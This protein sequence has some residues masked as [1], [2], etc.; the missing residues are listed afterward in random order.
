MTMRLALSL[1]LIMTSMPILMAHGNEIQQTPTTLAGYESFYQST[2]GYDDPLC[3][4]WTNG[5]ETCKRIYINKEAKISCEEKT[6]ACSVG[7]VY[8]EIEDEKLASK[9]CA[10]LSDDI[11]IGT[12]KPGHG[13][14]WTRAGVLNKPKRHTLLRCLKLR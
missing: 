3:L 5:C 11:N 4:Q 9:F 14:L 1:G 12:F 6:D 2:K 8:C 7:N 13:Y 10:V